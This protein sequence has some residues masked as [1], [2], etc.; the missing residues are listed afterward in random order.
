MPEKE[1]LDLLLVKKA[2][3]SPAIVTAPYLT[4]A[5]GAMVAF[6]G[7]H[8]EETGT[9]VMRSFTTPDSDTIQMLSAVAP[10]YEATRI[11]RL[12]WEQEDSH[13]D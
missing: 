13:G 4:G 9:I 5:E 1:L 11:F 6:A 10:I 12:Y 2:D 3:G 8:G 7:P